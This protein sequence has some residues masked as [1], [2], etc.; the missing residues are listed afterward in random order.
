MR[1]IHSDQVYIEGLLKNDHTVIDR[2]YS[3]FSGKVKRYIVFNSGSEDDAGDIFQ[4]ALIDIYNQA[5]YKNL[6]LTCPFEPF[7]LLICK[8][9]WLNELKKRAATPV[10]N[11]EN[12]LYDIGEDVFRMAEEL[13]EKQAQTALFQRMFERLSERCQEIIQLSLSDE[14]Q[15]KIAAQL[16][17]T[18]GYLRKKKSE[19][20]ATLTEWIQ[21]ERKKHDE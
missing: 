9:K 8:R 18:Y 21:K 7:L 6:Q 19:C 2:I 3:S 5:R 17:V 10:T 20:L 16:G 1:K 15:E 12:D 14:H 13:Y 4:E 11:Q